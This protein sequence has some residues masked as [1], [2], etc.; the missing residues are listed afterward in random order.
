M[1]NFIKV[2]VAY[3]MA[4]IVSFGLCYGIYYLALPTMN[5]ESAGFYFFFTIVFAIFAGTFGCAAYV[6]HEIRADRI[7]AESRAKGERVGYYEVKMAKR[8]LLSWLIPLILACVALI[9]FIVGIISGWDL[10]QDQNY[11]NIMTDRVIEKDIADYKVTADNFPKIEVVGYNNVDGSDFSDTASYLADYKFGQLGAKATQYVL[12]EGNLQTIDGVNYKVYPTGYA[13]YFKWKDNKENGCQDYILVNADEK[14]SKD[15]DSAK[16][17]TLTKP[18][19]Y[20]DDAFWGYDLDRKIRFS[21]PTKIFSEKFFE[22]DDNG[23]PYYIVPFY[24][25]SVGLFYGKTVEEVLVLDANT[26]VGTVYAPENLPEWVNA[27]YS[28][29]RMI[30]QYNWYTSYIHGWWNSFVKQKDVTQLTYNAEQNGN[31]YKAY[32]LFTINGETWF[33]VG[34]TSVSKDESNMGFIIGNLKTGKVERYTFPSAEEY[35]VMRNFEGN[36]KV[37]AYDYIA[38]FPMVINVDG[39]PTFASTLKNQAGA[40]KAYAFMELENINNVSINSNFDIAYEEYIKSLNPELVEIANK[41]A[42][43]NGVVTEIRSMNI[44]GTTS[45]YLFVNGQVYS[46]SA[47][48]NEKIILVNVGN[49]VTLTVAENA[50]GEI[51]PAKLK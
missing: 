20:S 26:G 6:A 31:T 2:T 27:I 38:S 1:K 48:D 34:E 4:A 16:V 15:T 49:S 10:F 43:V 33:Y 51:I 46:V 50:T 29:E 41:F 22:V 19:I 32:N 17:K 47:K 5:F 42:E 44:N 13:G 21:Y 45:F 35:S 8:H 39:V 37:K 3:L 14:I 9:G 36:E 28:P 12:K 24:K 11:R 18:I 40:T 30:Q 23:N 7:V 25:H